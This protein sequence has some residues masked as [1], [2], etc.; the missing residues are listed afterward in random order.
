[1]IDLRN[2]SLWTPISRIPAPPA[3]DQ[4][5][6]PKAYNVSITPD[7]KAQMRR[8]RELADQQDAETIHLA[9]QPRLEPDTRLSD[10]I[11]HLAK[12]MGTSRHH[13]GHRVHRRNGGGGVTQCWKLPYNQEIGW[14]EGLMDL[15]S[16][17]AGPAK[18]QSYQHGPLPTPMQ[19][20]LFQWKNTKQSRKWESKQM[21]WKQLM[22]AM[23]QNQNTSR[24]LHL[25]TSGTEEDTGNSWIPTSADPLEVLMEAEEDSIRDESRQYLLALLLRSITKR[26]RKALEWKSTGLTEQQISRKMRVSQPTINREIAKIQATA[27]TLGRN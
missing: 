15:P 20:L 16:E 7:P 13:Q 4:S 11:L 18:D 2:E 25:D 6:L 1:M 17:A 8:S 12:H 19:T 10:D 23:N 27:T 21:S 5:W 3:G 14:S 24:P 22:Q 9:Y 26:Q